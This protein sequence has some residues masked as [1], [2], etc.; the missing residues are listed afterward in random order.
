MAELNRHVIDMTTAVIEANR[1]DCQYQRRGIMY[2]FR[3]DSGFKKGIDECQLLVEH[4]IAGRV[5]SAEQ[6]RARESVVHDSV[7]GGV[8]YPGDADLVPD[9]FVKKL[10]KCLPDM[11]IDIMSNTRVEG[12]EITNGRITGVATS[13]RT[14][15]MSQ[16][17]LPKSSSHKQAISSSTANGGSARLLRPE[18]VVLAAGAWT[19]TL[20]RHLGVRLSMLPGKGYSITFQKQPGGPDKPVNLSEAKVA[21][22]PWQN[23]IRLA[24]TMELAGFSTGDQSTA[25]GC[26]RARGQGLLA[27]V[28]G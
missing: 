4:G 26:D 8:L 23:T 14:R 1:L 17:D 15:G 21:V 19:A 22:T 25:R 20:A 5:L 27:R 6:V 12:F 24:G 16:S 3:T 28:P 2:V 7:C 10:A 9:Q 18:N 11:G 13:Q